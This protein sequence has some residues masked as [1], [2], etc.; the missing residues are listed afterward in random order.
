MAKFKVRRIGLFGGGI[1][2]GSAGTSINL[3]LA[4][5]GNACVPAINASTPGTG[6]IAITGVDAAD[7]VFVVPASAT[8]TI[9]IGAT[10]IS[11]GA[12][13]SFYNISS[14]NGGASTMAFRY[15]VLGA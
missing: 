10:A 2:V 11:G 14:V 12:S 9:V 6:S 8:S 13:L 3:M 5:S 4:G 1:Q 15:F 7:H